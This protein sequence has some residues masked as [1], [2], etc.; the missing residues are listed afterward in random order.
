MFL[1]GIT[2]NR[3]KTELKGRIAAAVDTC[4]NL[5][6]SIKWNAVGVGNASL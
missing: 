4:D 3:P 1:Q 2:V 6:L 5:K